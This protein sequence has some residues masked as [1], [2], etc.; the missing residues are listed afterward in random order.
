[1]CP[2]VS[3]TAFRH[4]RRFIACDGT[5][6]KSKFVQTLLLAVGIDANGHTL[7]LAWGVV[8]SE[9]AESW[10][11]FFRNLHSALPTLDEAEWTF[12][13]DRDKGIDAAEVY[14]GTKIVRAFCCRHLEQNFVTKFRSKLKSFFWSA[15]RAKTTYIFEK[16]MAEIK[17]VNPE[18][19]QY[20]RSIVSPPPSSRILY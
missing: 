7:I 13:S 8:E 2:S 18:A 6:L 9:N 19:E 15:A 11:Y 12:I 1:V 16:V 3:N 17:A 20:L 4:C 14:L 5:F 10:E